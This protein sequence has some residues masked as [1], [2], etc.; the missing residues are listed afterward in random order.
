[1]LL[2][3]L[4]IATAVLLAISVVVAG[5]AALTI[6]VLAAEQATAESGTAPQ[7]ESKDADRAQ[8]KRAAGAAGLSKLDR[9][10][11][12]EPAYQSRP[13]YCLLV[14]GPQAKERGWVVLDGDPLY[15]E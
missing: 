13:K 1:M 7:P 5:A 11:K 8:D 12:K 10:I 15:V 4:K 2:T 14:F 3:K 9:T 6:P